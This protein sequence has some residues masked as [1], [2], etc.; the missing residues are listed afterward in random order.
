MNEAILKTVILV[1][2]IGLG[3]ILKAK[4]KLKDKTDG[5]KE[6]V[7][8]VALPATIF[9]ALMKIHLEA[10]MLIIPILALVF[11]FFIFYIT[12]FS[13]TALGVKKNSPTS[14][15]MLMLMPSLAP[16]L[17]CFPFII[18]FLGDES[19]ALA[20]MA[21]IGNKVFVL[22]FLYIIAMN[23]FLKT[24]DAQNTNSKDKIK[25]LLLSLIKE[26]INNILFVAIMLLSF[27]LN[28]ETLPAVVVGF[29]DK[30]SA[31]MTPL[32][33]I[34]IGLAVKL[35]QKNKGVV[36][37]LLLVR[38]GL[39][40]IFTATVVTL[41]GVTDTNLI[42]LATVIPLSSVSFW[43][44][45]HISLFN[46]K[47]ADLEISKDKKTFDVELA[48]MVLA[49]SLPMSTILILTILS[50]GTYFADT[51][52]IV[53]LGAALLGIGIIPYSISK[54]TRASHSFAKNRA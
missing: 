17:S 31:I 26:P 1:L 37:S 25:S 14:R 3:I 53:L 19:L 42:L 9:I 54:L 10:S 5:I 30:T 47:E 44:F 33:L 23:M 49:I 38:A 50:A 6:I 24:T 36:F 11:N 18:E 39:S 22:I 13:L 2:L 7:L 46:S 51:W 27:G 45:A 48:I 41:L 16:G 29:F 43:P 32:V 8:S 15:T 28:Y 20:A 34:F 4:F 21:D 52:K 35:K 40:L 12:P